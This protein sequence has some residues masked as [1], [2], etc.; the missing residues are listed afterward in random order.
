MKTRREFIKTASLLTAGA[1]AMKAFP[2]S[3]PNPQETMIGLQL[4][5]LRDTITE[6][7]LNV[8]IKVSQ[9]GYTSLEPYGFDGKFF[10]Y[11]AKEFKKVTDDLG[12]KVTSTHSSITKEN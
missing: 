7:T 12:M 10:G 8:L 5:T 1:M 2:F 6:D 4:Y 3:I 9:I 11:P